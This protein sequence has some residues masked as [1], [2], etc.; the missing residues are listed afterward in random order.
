[1]WTAAKALNEDLTI[2]VSG[3]TILFAWNYF[4]ARFE[5]RGGEK[6]T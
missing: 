6:N 2:I 1:M 5:I 4:E 3:S